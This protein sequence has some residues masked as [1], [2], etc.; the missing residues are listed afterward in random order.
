MLHH[1][2]DLGWG[3]SAMASERKS[4]QARKI[5][6]IA[7]ALTSAGYRTLDEQSKALGLCRSTTWTLVK[8]SHKASGL[9][10]NLIDRMLSCPKLPHCVREKVTEYVHERLEGTYGHNQMQLRRFRARL[11][12]K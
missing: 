10:A 9:S 2:D 3:L 5:S 4:R 7:E 6:E 11:S 12:G 1:R 8:S